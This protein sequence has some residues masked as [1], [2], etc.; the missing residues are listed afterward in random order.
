MSQHAFDG[1]HALRVLTALD[2]GLRVRVD[3]RLLQR[4]IFSVTG[5]VSAQE[6]T[7]QLAEMVSSLRVYSYGLRGQIEDVTAALQFNV[8]GGEWSFARRA[9][10]DLA[11]MLVQA[12]ERGLIAGSLAGRCAGR[13]LRI[14]ELCSRSAR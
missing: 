8:Q 13:A 11:D 5:N 3:T 7:A 2:F 10:Y 12:Q 6:L 4:T 14:A 9:A 1:R